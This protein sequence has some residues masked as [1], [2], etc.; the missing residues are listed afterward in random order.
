M[1]KEVP[2]NFGTSF[3]YPRFY[4]C[5]IPISLVY[6]VLFRGA[7]LHIGQVANIEFTILKSREEIALISP[8]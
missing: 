4:I 2:K 5:G 3:I 7:L 8:L 1:K 6:L